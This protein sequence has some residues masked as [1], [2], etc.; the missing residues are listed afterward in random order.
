M[1]QN[2]SRNIQTDWQKVQ[3]RKEKKDETQALESGRKSF[4]EAKKGHSVRTGLD[5]TVK[6]WREAREG[7]SIASYWIWH[8]RGSWGRDRSQIVGKFDQEIM[9]EGFD[10]L[11]NLTALV[12]KRGWR[13][14]FGG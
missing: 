14:H 9:T 1:L 5:L 10:L 12:L 4:S 3:W 2:D 11:R 8:G 13:S 6:Y 7:T